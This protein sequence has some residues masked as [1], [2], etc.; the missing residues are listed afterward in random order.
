MNAK[1]EIVL[2]D[3]NKGVL[4]Y[5]PTVA[6]AIADYEHCSYEAL[7]LREAEYSD[8]AEIVAYEVPAREG[9]WS[10]DD[11]EADIEEIGEVV[12]HYLDAE[13]EEGEVWELD[14]WLDSGDGG[15]LTGDETDEELQAKAKWMIAGVPDDVRLAFDADD[16]L[17]ELT[18]RRDRLQ[19]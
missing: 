2:V 3:L 17:S 1:T 7:N 14:D 11:D 10:A 5:G 6:A 15:E 18:R 13:E 4:G 9:G 12:G 16:L 19:D 8:D